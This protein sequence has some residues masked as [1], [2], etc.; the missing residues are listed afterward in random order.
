MSFFEQNSSARS[1]TRFTN[2]VNSIS[3]A[4]TTVGVTLIRET[5]SIV[6]LLAW[7][8]YLNWQLTLVTI[9]VAPFI[10]WV[11]RIVSKRL[12]GLSRSAMEGVGVMTHSLQES[13]LCQ[14]ILKV[15]AGEEQES[16]RFRRINEE[17]RG[18]AMRSAVAAAAGTPVLHILVSIAI[19]VVVYV[20]LIQSAQGTT[21]V[22]SF[23]S[24]IT[25]MLMLLTPLRALSGVNAPLQRGL[26]AAESVFTLLDTPLEDDRGELNPGRVS[27]HLEF[28]DI[29]FT[30]PGAERPA[31]SA[32]SFVVEAGSTV[33]LVGASGGGKSTL[34]ALLP[35]FHRPERGDIL[36]DGVNVNDLSLLA[37]RSQI[38][39]VSQETLLFNDTVRANIAYGGRADASE[40]EIEA[41]AA[42]ANALNFIRELPHGF[43][44]VIG[45]N[46]SRLS[47]GQRQRLA[48][49][50]AILKDA[51]ILILDEATSAL[52][53]ESERLVQEALENLM[54]MRTTLV[55]AH[56]L[57]TIEGADNIIVLGQG[58]ILESGNHLSLLGA[59]AA[60]AQLHRLQAVER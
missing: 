33:A 30:Y 54:K 35:R 12:R 43:E 10:A 5:L 40:E 52:D 31:L 26:A 27:G 55:I 56:R 45:E 3:T 57:S 22:G 21:S 32:V 18:N 8:L 39:V 47:G 51:P 17:L 2:D 25:A 34:A 16:E 4:V 48:I 9:A 50:R 41:A 38:A 44:T 23:V 53:N 28:R 49:A 19:G 59:N 7:M 20:A 24:F 36:I 37:L 1:I 15:F 42:A 14:K 13:I 11:T 29:T 6:G 60:Y 46:G 58:R